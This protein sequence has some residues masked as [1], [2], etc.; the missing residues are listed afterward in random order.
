[1]RKNF[2]RQYAYIFSTLF[3]LTFSPTNHIP[4]KMRFLAILLLV[5][6][7]FFSAEALKKRQ[8]QKDEQHQG[9]LRIISYE[10][11]IRLCC[12][13]LSNA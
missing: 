4:A 8:L 12:R 10:I 2:R 9:N 13:L 6:L 1:M 11:I 5:T 3:L 7:A